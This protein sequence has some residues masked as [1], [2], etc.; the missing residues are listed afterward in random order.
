MALKCGSLPR[1]AGDLAGLNTIGL[2]PLD[3]NADEYRTSTSP[4]LNAYTDAN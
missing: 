3:I 2:L 4:K 1:D